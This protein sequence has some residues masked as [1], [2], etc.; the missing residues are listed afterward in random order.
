MGFMVVFGLFYQTLLNVFGVDIAPGI[1]TFCMKI[2]A[3]PGIENFL[4]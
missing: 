3:I 1:I 2:L 4:K